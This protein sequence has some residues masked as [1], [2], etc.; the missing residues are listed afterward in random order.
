MDDPTRNGA[1]VW[2][3]L[4]HD[5]SAIDRLAR[6]CVCS[7]IIAQLLLN[8]RSPRQPI[9]ETFLACPLTGLLEPERLPG[10]DAAVERLFAA[11]QEKKKIC[12]YG[13][14]DVDG[15]TGTAIS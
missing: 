6:R 15:V 4:P 12:I 8:R 3:L 9:A 13:D 11:I 10:I 5:R 14:Y 7:P 2:H 1:K